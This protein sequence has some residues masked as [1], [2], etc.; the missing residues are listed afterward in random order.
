[1]NVLRSL[2]PPG[3]RAVV[4]SI[5]LLA[6]VTS[7]KA[8]DPPQDYDAIQEFLPDSVTLDGKVVYIDFWASWCVPCRQSFPWLQEL[9]DSHRSRGFEIIGISVDKDPRAAAKFVDEHE[10]TFPIIIDSAGT[11]AELYALEAMPT[12]YIFDK[13]GHVLIRH[14]GFREDDADSLGDLIEQSLQKESTK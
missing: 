4:I 14:Q 11:L 5:L 8:A 2:P 3:K 13:D 7:T 9:Y 12:S 6:L 1:M 10:T